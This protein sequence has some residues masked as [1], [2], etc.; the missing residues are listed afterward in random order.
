MDEE[1]TPSYHGE[2][3]RHNGEDPD[4]EIACDECDYFL[5]CFPEYDIVRS[6]TGNMALSDMELTEED[7]ERIQAA[8]GNPKDAEEIVKQLVEKHTARGINYG[9]K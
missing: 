1:L 7:K 5:A 2:D 3:C 9:T 8:A 4:F 6:V